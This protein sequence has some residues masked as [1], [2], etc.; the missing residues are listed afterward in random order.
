MCRWINIEDEKPI[1]GSMCLV[2][3]PD[4]DVKHELVRYAGGKWR[5]SL[6]MVMPYCVTH[7]TY[8]KSPALDMSHTRMNQRNQDVYKLYL[9]KKSYREICKEL[10]LSYSI[11]AGIIKRR[12]KQK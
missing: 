11:V 8:I 10:G 5:Y 12:K 3:I 7:W 4:E 2:Y 6:S 1:E 9:Q